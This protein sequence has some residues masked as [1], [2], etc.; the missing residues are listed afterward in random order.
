[1]FG[2]PETLRRGDVG[3]VQEAGQPSPRGEILKVGR[4]GRVGQQQSGPVLAVVAMAT[5]AVFGEQF[6]PLRERVVAEKRDGAGAR[7]AVGPPR[8]DL[9]A[10]GVFAGLADGGQILGVSL[11]SLDRLPSEQGHSRQEN[12]KKTHIKT[13]PKL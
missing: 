7:D 10:F 12:I 3:G 13:M 2:C 11:V 1:M 5:G 9:D 8:Q 4:G 6:W